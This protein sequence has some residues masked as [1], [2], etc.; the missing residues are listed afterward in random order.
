MKEAVCQIIL[1]FYQKHL[2]IIK[3]Q[4]Q[5]HTRKSKKRKNHKKTVRKSLRLWAIKKLF[6]GIS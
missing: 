5:L 6:L 3:F 1:K 4:G 2:E